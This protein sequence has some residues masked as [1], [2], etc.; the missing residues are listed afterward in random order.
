M[1]ASID[2]GTNTVLLLVGE[3]R[4]GK[5]HIIDEAHRAPRL[6]QG[7]DEAQKLT[8]EAMD[9]V[10]E[11]LA[12]YKKYVE[13]YHPAV[14]NIH[15]TATSA[16][17]D[18][19]NRSVF[20]QK[21]KEDTGLEV[22]VL[23]GLEE[24]RFTFVGA[25]SVLEKDFSSQK[26]VIIDIGGG[27]TEIAIGREEKV[28]DSYSFDMGCVRF[29][30]RYLKNDPLSAKQIEH[31][32]AAIDAMLNTYEFEIEKN[33]RLIGVAGT[34]TSLAFIDRGMKEYN[35]SLL[36]GYVIPMNKLNKYI[37]L[38]S[39]I[40]SG[41]LKERYPKVME[42]RADIFRAGLF[43]LERFMER[44][45]FQKLRVSTGGIRHGAVCLYSGKQS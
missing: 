29:T 18:A 42:K 40:K 39:R 7:V 28:L 4:Q 2:I 1:R 30:E 41:E 27:S 17:R 36:N 31:C 15:V 32:R 25:L 43:I 5:L 22:E 8:S 16:V 35:P 34:V 23:N 10:I 44:Y 9:R 13:Q 19:Q 26:K 20:L 14:D 6:G 3:L 37:T 38:F 33:T 11:V 21:I 12:E 45:S 24:A